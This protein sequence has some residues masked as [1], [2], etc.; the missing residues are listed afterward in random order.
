MP[1]PL[2]LTRYVCPNAML[3]CYLFDVVNSIDRR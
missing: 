1:L 3:L 2:E